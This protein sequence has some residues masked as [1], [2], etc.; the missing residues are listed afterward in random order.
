MEGGAPRSL[1]DR[2]YLAGLVTV[3]ALE[4]G[5]VAVQL[6]TGHAVPQVT[7]VAAAL[8]VACMLR[9]HGLRGTMA[10]IALVVAIP[11]GS[12]FLGVLTGIPYGPYAYNAA[13]GPWLFGLVPVFILVAWINITY[14]VLATTTLALGRSRLWLAFLD[15]ALAASWDAMVDP[16]AVRAGYW[17]WLSPGGLYGV[18]FTN[19]LGWFAVVTL[20]SL[21]VRVLWS[22]GVAAPRPTT[23]ATAA[24]LPALL[25]ASAASFASLS[26][27]SGFLLSAVIGLVFPLPIVAAAWVKVAQAPRARAAPVFR[28][29]AATPRRGS[30]E[31]NGRS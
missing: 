21:V 30:A 27:G 22:R 31:E 3:L 29:S 23:R 25:V 12:E 18:P 20:F 28:V 9:L 14:L 17:V 8:V 15:G 6:A 2:G 19:F 10:F 5:G 7:L 1:L 16:L 26:V 11:F 24:I 4:A 13:L